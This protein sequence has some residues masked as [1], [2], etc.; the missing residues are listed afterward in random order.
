MMVGQGH[1]GIWLEQQLRAH[2]LILKQVPESTFGRFKFYETL[3]PSLSDTPHPTRLYFLILPKQFHQ[4]G[5]LVFMGGNIIPTT[6][7]MIINVIYQLDVVH[8][9]LR[10]NIVLGS[11]SKCVDENI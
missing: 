3:K 7:H 11:V 9:L 4:L 5:T 6:T 8:E 1:G 10:L 2:I